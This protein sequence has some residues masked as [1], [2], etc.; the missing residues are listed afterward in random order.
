MNE[1]KTQHITILI[2]VTCFVQVILSLELWLPVQRDFPLVSFFDFLPLHLNHGIRIFLLVIM[3]LHLLAIFIKPKSRLIFLLFSLGGLILVLE[4]A[5]RLQPWFYLHLIMISLIAF[6]SK[7]STKKVILFLQIS[8][9]AIYFWGGFNKLNVAFAWDI[10]PWLMEPFGINEVFFLGYDN[11]NSFPLPALNYV[12][13]FIP[14][15]EISTAFF[16]IIPRFRIVGIVLCVLT[17]V[18]SLYI[19]GPLGHN[20]NSV[21]W[22]WN[23]Q[24][25]ILCYLL[26]YRNAQESNFHEYTLALKSKLGALFIFLF[27]VIPVAGFWGKWDKGMALHLYSGNS[28]QMTFFFEGFQEKLVESSFAPYLSFDTITMT[29]FMKVRHWANDQLKTP[30]YGTTRHSKKVGTYLCSCLESQK[31]SGILIFT[32]NGFTSKQDTLR[33]SCDE[34]K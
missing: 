34:L 8:V 27:L 15:V 16:L 23:I 1:N 9:I 12:A 2:L 5:M 25:P 17:H 10:F 11:L 3:A 13:Y 7:L 4:D 19:I 21:V 26:F 31:N 6:E 14:I 18:F 20:W 29:S 22:P 32:R 28:T 33:Y 24:M 30:M